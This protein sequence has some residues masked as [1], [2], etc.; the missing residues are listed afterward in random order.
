MPGLIQ[1]VK[2]TI[3]EWKMLS[4]GETVIA[5]VSGGADSVVMLHVL[6]ELS[7]ELGLKLIVAHMDHGL[8]GRE[9]TRDHD[10]V[11]DLS[12]RLSLEFVSRRLEKGELKGLKGSAQEAARLRRYA[13]LEETAAKHKAKRVALG[14]TSDDQSET[15]LMRLMKGASLSGLSGIPPQRGIFIRPLIQSTRSSVEGYARAR[16][17]AYVID[18]S[19]LTTKY[20]RNSVRLELL[21]YL[22]KKYNPSIKEALARTSLVLS[23]DDEFIEGAA[24]RAF[25]RALVRKKADAVVFDRAK[26]LR[27]HRALCSRVF[28][29]AVHG[30]GLEAD[31]S[32]A[33]VDAFYGILTGASPN[34]SIALPGGVAARR[35][36]TMLVVSKAP[37]QG[38]TGEI[39]LTVP[40]TTVT[41][42]LQAIY[43]RIIRPPRKFATGPEVAWFDYDALVSAGGLS[44]RPPR[45]GDRI[46]PFGMTGTRK[47]K[48]IFIDAKVP[49]AQRKT[50]PVVTAGSE[51]LW[52]AG[53]RQSASFSV[54]KATRR[55]LRLEFIKEDI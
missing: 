18:S 52:V 33:H 22:E 15:V 34:A 19:N 1:Q 26:L 2:K 32:S 28:L 17:L 47:L 50:T 31:L 55:A 14:H 7:G 13:F 23:R 4:G 40:G 48:D 46:T 54:S 3:K 49:L 45:P 21:P 5:A 9:S 6:L 37:P 43:A 11:R 10:F 39:S 8:R 44:A 16:S 24:S 20:L 38:A 25:S 27:M 29:R 12:G 53:L 41:G 35:E 42:G 36:Y 51:I 30:L